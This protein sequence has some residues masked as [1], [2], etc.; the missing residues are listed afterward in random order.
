MARTLEYSKSMLALSIEATILGIKEAEQSILLSDLE[1]EKAEENLR[2][3]RERFSAK[4]E[5]N[6]V[7]MDA[8]AALFRARTNRIES[9]S[10]HNVK[11][12]ALERILGWER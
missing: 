12:S 3:V 5:T 4:E 1:I 11:R 2:I 9:L 8:E 7:V 6:S 10:N